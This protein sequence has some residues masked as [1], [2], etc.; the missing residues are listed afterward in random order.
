M[1]DCPKA[2]ETSQPSPAAAS[3]AGDTTEMRELIR[4]AAATVFRLLPWPTEPGLR[5]IGSPGPESPVLVT[6]NYDLTVRRLFRALA[7][8]DAWLVVAP[9]SG[10]N[11]WCAAAGG[12]LT[13]SRVVTALKTSGIE[14]I[15]RHRRAVLPQLAATGVVTQEV[16]RRTGWKLRFGPVYAEDL[17]RYLAAGMHKDDS[18]RRVRFGARERME[19]T[20]AWAGPA[21]L[22]LAGLL[23]WLHRAWALP[24]AV[25]TWAIATA[26]FFF[27]DRMGRFRWPLAWLTCV[28]LSLVSVQAA[29]AQLT[30]TIAAVGFATFNLGLC[31]FDYDGST[32]I[33]GGSHFENKV[34]NITLDAERCKGIFSCWEVCPEACFEKSFEPRKARLAHDER[35]IKCGACI[36]QCPED[37]LFFTAPDGE[38]IE[39]ETIRRYKLNLLGQRREAA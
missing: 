19:M 21:S 30:G 35:C 37:A 12:L 34:W 13:T 36:V 17:P 5:R 20:V 29:G 2:G 9:S 27:Y 16:A 18:M 11:V 15:V 33:A 26:V 10:I 8:V 7:G 24:V 14:D 1:S 32:P 38:R 31:T 23:A 4:D 22:V 3:P 6:G 39:P 28:G 25:Q